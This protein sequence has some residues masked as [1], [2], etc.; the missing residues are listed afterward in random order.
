[1][2]GAAVQDTTVQ[3]G[4]KSIRTEG[5]GLGE[6]IW[7]G[8][9]GMGRGGRGEALHFGEIRPERPMIRSRAYQAHLV[10]SAY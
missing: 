6:E 1:M 10:H 7:V 4:K 3:C 2:W 8:W 9:G 5:G